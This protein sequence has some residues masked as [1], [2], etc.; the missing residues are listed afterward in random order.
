MAL[1]LIREHE[2]LAIRKVKGKKQEIIKE[3][4]IWNGFLPVYIEDLIDFM[5]ADENRIKE[6]LEFVLEERKKE[7][8]EKKKRFDELKEFVRRL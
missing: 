3:F 4:S 5:N 2:A 8:E 1:R 6:F 7:L